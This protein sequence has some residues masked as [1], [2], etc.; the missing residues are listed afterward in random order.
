MEERAGFGSDVCMAL[1]TF[2]VDTERAGLNAIV[3]S[4]MRGVDAWCE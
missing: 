2:S 1:E 3:L 4:Q